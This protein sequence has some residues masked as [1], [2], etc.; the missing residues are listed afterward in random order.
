MH[1]RHKGQMPMNMLMIPPIHQLINI[2]RKLVA[3]THPNISFSVFPDFLNTR[4]ELIKMKQK[5]E[6]D[7][8]YELEHCQ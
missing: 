7:F 8:L 1:R 6:I 3:I 5:E 2:L 4:T